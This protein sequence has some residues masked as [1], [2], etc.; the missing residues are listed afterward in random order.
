MP[1]TAES[2]S[3]AERAYATIREAILAGRHA[4][5][6]MLGEA[7]LATELGVSRTPV[8][9]ALVRLQDEGWITI[10]PKRG[11]LV[12][13]VSPEEARDHADARL[14]LEGAAV[15]RA[16]L[17]DRAALADR[18]APILEAQARVLDAGEVDR[19]VESTIAF[20]R[21]FVEVSG[22]PVLLELYDRLADRHRLVLL[23]NRDTLV[24]R[25]VDIAAEHRELLDELRA[26]TPDRFA[27]RLA[28]HIGEIY[29]VVVRP[30]RSGQ[31]A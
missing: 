18:L 1:T 30:A 27:E 26:E 29:H 28:A 15:A 6:S 24:A 10:Y 12:R 9:A 19:Y 14:V 20:H 4:P 5:G 7:P 8:R 22:N 21:A 11:A 2:A 16:P 13:E 23:R 17:A 25:S 31:R 3:A